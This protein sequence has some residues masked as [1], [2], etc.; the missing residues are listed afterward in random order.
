MI[1]LSYSNDMNDES[2]QDHVISS[3][4]HLLQQQQY[5][6]ARSLLQHS[7]LLTKRAIE[8]ISACEDDATLLLSSKLIHTYTNELEQLNVEIKAMFCRLD[9]TQYLLQRQW[10]TTSMDL[11]TDGRL[12]TKGLVTAAPTFPLNP[13]RPLWM[14]FEEENDKEEGKSRD[15][16]WADVPPLPIPLPCKGVFFDIAARYIDEV[17]QDEIIRPLADH[18]ALLDK[19]TKT[20]N[21]STLDMTTET[22]TTSQ[23]SIFSNWFSSK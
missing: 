10:Q 2:Q 21:L 19:T 22:A 17:I 18:S 11:V 8:E 6:A 14:Q 16:T 20:K 7:Q 23:N 15:T 1:G 9:A 5:V 3:N 4:V 12:A 13:D